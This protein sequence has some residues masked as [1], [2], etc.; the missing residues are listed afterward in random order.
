MVGMP[1]TKKTRVDTVDTRFVDEV[2]IDCETGVTGEQQTAH[3]EAAQASTV[4]DATMGPNHRKWKA[5]L[6]AFEE[7][8][9]VAVRMRLLADEQGKQAKLA[10]RLFAAKWK[11]LEAGDKLKRR[12]KLFGAARRSYEAII[13][14]DQALLKREWYGRR[15][16][17]AERDAAR[18]EV[19]V[20]ELQ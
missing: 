14:R 5:A 15:A 9:M 10:E 3:E 1:K 16:A 6:Q 13:D 7:A 17:K 2:D 19:R 12:K 8:S 11:R 18:A 4:V 20:M